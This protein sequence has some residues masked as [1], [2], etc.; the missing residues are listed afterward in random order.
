MCKNIILV[1]MPGSGKST[2][3]VV[4]AKK[5]RYSFLDSDLLI[6]Q[7]YG[8]SLEQ[9]IEEHGDTGFI[10]IEN[11]VNKNIQVERTVIATG[12]SAVYGKEAMQH[13]KEIGTV[14][15]LKVDETAIAKRV[16]SLKERGVVANGKTTIEEIFEERKYLYETYAD[17]TVQMTDESIADALEKL[18]AAL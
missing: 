18:V 14:V 9:L 3:G 8:K 10:A 17:I 11:G 2:L 12:G 6:Q 16:G 13:L 15:Y 4:L 7:E 1:G 5:L